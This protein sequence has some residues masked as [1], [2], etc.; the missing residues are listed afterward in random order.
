MMNTLKGCVRGKS[1]FSFMEMM[2]VILIIS[3]LATGVAITLA[4]WPGRAERARAKA[5][6][7]NLKMKIDEYKIDQG[8]YPT[9]EQ[10]LDAL[11]SAP[12]T[13]PLPPKYPEDAYLYTLEVPKDPWNNDYVY[14]VPGQDGRPYEIISYGKDGEPGGEGQDADLSSLSLA[15]D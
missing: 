3:I 12:T 1:G 15:E 10:G 5:E 14:V 13:P 4:K 2:V 11:C 8:M 6:N 7:L 9:Q